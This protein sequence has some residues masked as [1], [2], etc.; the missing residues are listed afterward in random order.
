MIEHSSAMRL[1][2]QRRQEAK[3]DL[4]MRYLLLD[5][6][7]GGCHFNHASV[8]RLAGEKTYLSLLLEIISLST[9]AQDD[10]RI[11]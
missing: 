1:R 5:R 7:L 2:E 11:V 6:K 8:A 3:I 10:Q 9:A 4:E